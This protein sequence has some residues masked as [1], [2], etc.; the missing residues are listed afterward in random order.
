MS[1][2]QRFLY[3]FLDEAGNLDF[4]SKG[5]RYFVLGCISKERPFHAYRE[6][7]ELKYDLVEQRTDIEYFHASEDRQATRDAVFKIICSNIDGVR[8]DAVVVEKRKASAAL[9]ADEKFYPKMLGHLLRHVLDKHDLRLFREAIVFTDRLPV[10][11][12]RNAIEK[13]VK[14]TLAAMLPKTATYRIYHHDSKS[15]IDLQ[16]SDYFNWAVYRK[17]ERQDERSYDLIKSA[18]KSEFDIFRSGKT[19]YY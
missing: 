1:D 4:S 10:A 17:W 3:I 11:K 16:I 15:N 19:Y 2:L 7:T 12:K 5:T 13:A 18:S 9:Q 6:L 14:E 8:Y